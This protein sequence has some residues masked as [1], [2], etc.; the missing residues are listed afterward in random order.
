MNIP[1]AICT[2]GFCGPNSHQP[3]KKNHGESTWW[4][5]ITCRHHQSIT[6]SIWSKSKWQRINMEEVCLKSSALHNHLATQW[7]LW[8]GIFR[9]DSSNTWSNKHEWRCQLVQSHE[10]QRILHQKALPTTI[11]TK[12]HQSF[13]GVFSSTDTL[14]VTYVAN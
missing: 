4:M 14:A 3:K 1:S 5:G 2:D 6:R 10:W 12:C 13:D 11:S 7:V 8:W 9:S